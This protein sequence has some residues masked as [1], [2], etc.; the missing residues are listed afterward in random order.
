[1]LQGL[2]V[3]QRFH[4]VLAFLPVIFAVLALMEGG[5]SFTVG[6]LFGSAFVLILWLQH[7]VVGSLVRFRAAVAEGSVAQQ[8]WGNGELAKLAVAIDE[9]SQHLSRIVATVEEKAE[10]LEASCEII[11]ALTS[12]MNQS[13]Q[14]QSDSIS[15]LNNDIAGLGQSVESEAIQLSSAAMAAKE[16]QQETEKGNQVVAATIEGIEHL[17]QEV[18]EASVVI[19]QLGEDSKN[20]GSVLDVIRG[21]AEQTNLLALNA[22]IE[23][24]RAGESGRGF[25]VVADEVRTLASR[26]QQSTEEIQ[27]TIEKL[28]SGAEKAVQRI[29]R[30]NEQAQKTVEQASD[31]GE[32]LSAIATAVN[33][34]SDI[35]HTIHSAIDEQLVF[36]KSVTGN[37]EIV[38]EQ[39][40]DTAAR[41]GNAADAAHQLA[42]LANEL[43]Q[44]LNR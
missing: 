9:A 10:L 19:N 4:L 28:Q 6:V 27:L 5:V 31:A 11:D 15:N 41:A 7:S 37:A 30:G 38:N 39:S 36:M 14:M 35:N 12:N 1:M 24:A 17:A 8:N 16:A 22:A 42:E 43:K 32:A 2:S 25:A 44:V 29:Y 18:S 13:T 26:T 3:K 20:I 33:A 34:I 23:A 21:I 40:S